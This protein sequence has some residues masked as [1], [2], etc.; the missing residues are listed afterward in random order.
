MRSSEIFQPID[1]QARAQECL[2]VSKIC[3]AREVSTS[4]P[5]GLVQESSLP[6]AQKVTP[7]KNIVFEV[8]VD[9][10]EV[11]LNALDPGIQ[12]KPSLADNQL[13]AK[14]RAKGPG[15]KGSISPEEHKKPQKKV[16]KPRIIGNLTGFFKGIFYRNG[17]A[18]PN[19]R[20]K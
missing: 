11:K 7:P 2:D 10:G 16:G 12:V 1:V 20:K 17:V 19:G 4:L 6:E 15:K 14:L 5:L 3:G 13:P 9:Q 18:N 8:R